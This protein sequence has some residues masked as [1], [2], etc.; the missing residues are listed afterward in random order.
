MKFNNRKSINDKLSKYIPYSQESEFV[1][2]TGWTN[3][4][5]WDIN[6]NDRTISLG[7]EELDMINFLTKALDYGKD[8]L[9]SEGQ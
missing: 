3:E 4:E 6:I 2:V 9:D 7:R 5:G 1:E 8:T